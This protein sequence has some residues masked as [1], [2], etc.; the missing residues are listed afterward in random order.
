MEVDATDED[1]LGE[2]FCDKKVAHVMFAI[3]ASLKNTILP[4]T[5]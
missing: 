1:L 3:K 2:A 5:I 4:F